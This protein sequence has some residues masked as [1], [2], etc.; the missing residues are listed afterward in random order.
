MTDK[1]PIK[2]VKGY[3]L[4]AIH[5]Q[6]GNFILDCIRIYG[7]TSIEDALDIRQ[8]IYLALF[9]RSL[10]ERFPMGP[11]LLGYIKRAASNAVVDYRR[12]QHRENVIF[13]WVSGNDD[14]MGLQMDKA[15]FQL[16]W[17]ANDDIDLRILQSIEFLDQ[18]EPSSG[19]PMR[20]IMADIYGG[21]TC[22]T[23]AEKYEVAAGTVSSWISRFRDDLRNHMRKLSDIM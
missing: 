3:N 19:V 5:A 6:Y 10:T 9:R 23:I 11:S 15:S 2:T 22:E 21:S 14:I 16:W 12:T 4:S 8:N 18:Y 17:A 1:P 20:D 7:V 13:D